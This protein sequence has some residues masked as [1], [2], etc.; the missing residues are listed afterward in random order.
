MSQAAAR[1]L[2]HRTNLRQYVLDAAKQAHPQW[3]VTRVDPKLLDLLEYKLGE[4]VRK[5]VRNHPPTGKT[6]RGLY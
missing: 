3:A 1:K 4:M 2:V 5:S 6:V